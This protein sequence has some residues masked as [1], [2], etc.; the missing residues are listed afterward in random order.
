MIDRMQKSYIE[1]SKKSI[2]LLGPRQVGKSTLIK[3]L[4]PDLQINFSDEKTL[5]DFAGQP[6]SLSD[7]LERSK[8]KSVFIDEVQRLPSILNTVQAIVDSNKNIKFYLT[9]SS[10][11]KLKRGGANLLPGRVLNY[12]LGPIV[13]KE[14]GYKID[15]KK[16]LQYGFLPEI[17]TLRTES[18]I[19]EVLLSYTANYIREEI[20]AEALVRSLESFTRFLN[21]IC[22]WSGQFVDYTK[23][24]K[25]AQI[26]RHTC[27]NYFEILEDTMIGY[28]IFPNFD[29]L[30]RIDLVKH[31]KFF[32]FDVGV[33]NALDRSFDTSSRR[34]GALV[35]QL[36]FQQIFHSA[37]AAKKIFEIN[38][39]RTRGGLEADFLV[40][41]EGQ[42]FLIEAK[43]S[44]E[45]QDSDFS[46]LE[47]IKKQ[48][49]NK[50][51]TFIFHSGVKA[52]KVDSTWSLPMAE[53][54]K[55]MG[56]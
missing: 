49:M 31:P 50:A 41:L 2:L 24:S 53:G 12:S 10:A 21:E 54:L 13:A 32:F 33:L 18:D 5:M 45:V 7:L 16:A 51:T 23:L 46:S 40:K 44:E 11:R 42:N 6:S 30:E 17:L 20:Q 48:Y 26:S 3:S 52:R 27:P 14:L 56:L 38:S 29:L 55:E 8:A 39:F 28:R 35:E 43:A 36:I 34:I 22:R 9:G 37:N 47:V 1:V 4:K 15:M 25:R 19:K